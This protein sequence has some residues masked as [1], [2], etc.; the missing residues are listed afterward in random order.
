MDPST[1][2]PVVQEENTSKKFLHSSARTTRGP[3]ITPAA[4]GPSIRAERGCGN[5]HSTRSLLLA[6]SVAAARGPNIL[7][8]AAT[9]FLCGSIVPVF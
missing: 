9:Q 2:A 7:V 3:G 6:V 1:C 4:G 5:R 8:T